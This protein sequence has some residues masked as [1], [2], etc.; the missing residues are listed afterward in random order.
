MLPQPAP[1]A[2]ISLNI[3]MR[4][5]QTFCALQLSISALRKSPCAIMLRYVWRLKFSS[6][7]RSMSTTH[8][9]P[10][11][12]STILLTFQPRA[13]A[14]GLPTAPPAAGESTLHCDGG[15]WPAIISN[16]LQLVAPNSLRNQPGSPGPVATTAAGAIG[17][18]LSEICARKAVYGP[19]DSCGKLGTSGRGPPGPGPVT[20]CSPF[21]RHVSLST[22]EIQPGAGHDGQMG[23][24]LSTAAIVVMTKES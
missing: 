6:P 24:L 23:R 20:G 12:A 1:A 16:E 5:P 15:I 9:S 21:G 8:C 22:P 17:I 11:N 18:T 10:K 3:Q 13:P 19:C 7:L 14:G 4:L 2:Q